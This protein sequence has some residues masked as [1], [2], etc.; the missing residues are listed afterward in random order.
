[1]R[2]LK[3]LFMHALPLS[4]MTNEQSAVMLDGAEVERGVRSRT[5]STGR[6]LWRASVPSR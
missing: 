4:A 5:G 3:S 2:P 1:M 6:A